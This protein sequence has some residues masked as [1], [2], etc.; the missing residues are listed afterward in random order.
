VLRDKNKCTAAGSGE[1]NSDQTKTK[2]EMEIQK[3]TRILNSDRLDE[4]I[5][6]KTISD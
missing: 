1:I 4:K 6:E 3:R 5:L 2:S